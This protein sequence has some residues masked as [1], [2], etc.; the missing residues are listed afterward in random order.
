MAESDGT[1]N[2]ETVAQGAAGDEPSALA[3]TR[4]RL[5][6]SSSAAALALGAVPIT[7]CVARAPT[8]PGEPFDDGTFFDDGTGWVE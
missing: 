6:E 5:L 1:A 3:I 4:R 8:S 7:A 2:S